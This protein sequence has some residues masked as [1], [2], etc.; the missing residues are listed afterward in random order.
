MEDGLAGKL[1]SGLS[2]GVRSDGVVPLRYSSGLSCC[3]GVPVERTSMSSLEFC[4]FGRW[5][6]S[7]LGGGGGEERRERGRQRDYFYFVDAPRV[8]R[9]TEQG[10]GGWAV[11]N[12][13]V[14]LGQRC[15]SRWHHWCDTEPALTPGLQNHS[16]HGNGFPAPEMWRSHQ[17][18]RAAGRGF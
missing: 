5:H 12:S 2:S 14:G 11:G 7:P 15:H 13:G 8:F 10:A 1:C 17:R 4:R 6:S 9:G 18:C 3:R 16:Q